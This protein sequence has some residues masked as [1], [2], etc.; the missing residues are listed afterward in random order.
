MKQEKAINVDVKYTAKQQ[1]ALNILFD[2]ETIELVYGGAKGGGKTVLGAMWLLI[3]AT[4][5]PGSRGLIGREEL[6]KHKQTTLVT[7]FN[8][9]A[10]IGFISTFI[11]GYIYETAGAIYFLLFLL[12]CDL[13]TAVMRS[14]KDKSFSSRRLPRIFVTMISYCLCLSIGFNAAKFS[15]LLNFLPSTLLFAFYSVLIVSI[16]EN[17]VQLK[18]LPAKIFKN[19]LN[20]IK[21]K[22]KE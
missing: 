5:F 3:M 6:I 12:G 10:L 7:L 11:T 20:K 21:K 14:I 8:N 18:I 4:K 9:A 16:F 15:P 1:E 22:E 13:L 2:K 19:I 17:L